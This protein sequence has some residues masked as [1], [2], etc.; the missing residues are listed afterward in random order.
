MAI[1]SHRYYD[2]D[3]NACFGTEGRW[4]KGYD[5]EFCPTNGKNVEPMRTSFGEEVKWNGFIGNFVD[6][7]GEDKASN[8]GAIKGPNG[9]HFYVFRFSQCIGWLNENN[10]EIRMNRTFVYAGFNFDHVMEHHKWL[11]DKMMRIG[12]FSMW[13]SFTSSNDNV[14]K[15]KQKCSNK[16]M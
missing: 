4:Y 7:V 14:I 12:M 13:Q 3:W 8:L 5:V 2:V 6:E 11:I 15:T 10:E 1:E 9:E 16:I